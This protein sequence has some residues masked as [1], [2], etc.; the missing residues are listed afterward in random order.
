MVAVT[1]GLT[2]ETMIDKG[3]CIYLG[4]FNSL[5]SVLRERSPVL[6]GVRENPS[7]N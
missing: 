6:L 4:D 2:E 7:L 5:G 3:L 1:F